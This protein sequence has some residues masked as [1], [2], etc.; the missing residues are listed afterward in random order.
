MTRHSLESFARAER[1][2][3]LIEMMKIGRA[4]V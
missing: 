2:F 1:G 3:S 4:H